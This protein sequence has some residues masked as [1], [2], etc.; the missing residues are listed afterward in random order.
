MQ[1]REEQTG[2]DYDKGAEPHDDAVDLASQ[3][4][5]HLA[6]RRFDARNILFR[7]DVLVNRVEDLGG[8]ALGRL[9]VD[10]PVRQGVGQRE[11]VGQLRLP[12]YAPLVSSQRKS[13]PNWPR[14]GAPILRQQSGIL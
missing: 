5:F 14:R 2:D 13:M 12:K 7:G 3:P 10:I 9:A 8:N 6:Q 4:Q 11:S 1:C